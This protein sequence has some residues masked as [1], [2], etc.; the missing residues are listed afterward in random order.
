MED[1]REFAVAK[2]AELLKHPDDL[3]GKV[4]ALRRKFAKEKV[5]IDAQLNSGAQS[6]LDNVQEGLETLLTSQKQCEMINANMQKIDKLCYGARGMIQDFPR[7]N[8][9]SLSGHR[10][11]QI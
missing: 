11:R 1:A 3:N 10:R 6:Q 2:L 5:S 4:T 8:K 7:I 9:V